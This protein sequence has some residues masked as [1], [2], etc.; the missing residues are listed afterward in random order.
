MAE[1]LFVP[2]VLGVSL[3]DAPSERDAVAVPVSEGDSEA[4][5]VVDVEA[6]GVAD[7][8]GVGVVCGVPVEDGV[9]VGVGR[10]EPVPDALAPALI[11]DVGVAV[12]LGVLVRV[13]VDDGDVVELEDGVRVAVGVFDVGMEY[14][15]VEDGEDTE[16]A[17]ESDEDVTEDRGL[18]VG[19]ALAGAL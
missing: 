7:G 16:D 1:R 19:L 2:D 15:E 17:V 13:V 8:V 11:E 12:L 10:F 14:V 18:A 5:D 3:G 6:V 9:G 4:L